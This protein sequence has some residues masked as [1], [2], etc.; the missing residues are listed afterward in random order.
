MIKRSRI[1]SSRIESNPSKCPKIMMKILP[2]YISRIECND[3]HPG[4]GVRGYCLLGGDIW[5]SCRRSSYN[6]YGRSCI[7]LCFFVFMQRSRRMDFWD[8][9]K[10]SFAQKISDLFAQCANSAQTI[11][12]FCTYLRLA[13][14]NFNY[15]ESRR[16]ML[17]S[18]NFG[19]LY[20]TFYVVAGN[21]SCPKL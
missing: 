14:L 12:L 17:H 15:G 11:C 8:L 20:G 4:S 6:I 18:M 3:G 19:Q 10:L 16:M 2:E 1:G 9:H 21:F 5:S 13:Q 7:V